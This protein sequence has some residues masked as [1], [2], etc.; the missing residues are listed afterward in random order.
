MKVHFSDHPSNPI[1]YTFYM[2]KYN[3]YELLLKYKDN[4]IVRV[5][6]QEDKRSLLTGCDLYICYA[7]FLDGEKVL[8]VSNSRKE[9]VEMYERISITY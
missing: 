6:E 4:G 1:C 9:L 3:R 7:Y 8:A 2:K 5:E